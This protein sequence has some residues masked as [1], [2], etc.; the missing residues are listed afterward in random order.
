M[1]KRILDR[2]TQWSAAQ[3]PVLHCAHSFAARFRSVAGT[4]LAQS[5]QQALGTFKQ[6]SGGGRRSDLPYLR[7]VCSFIANQY[8]RTNMK[9]FDRSSGTVYSRLK[10][11]CRMT[12]ITR[13]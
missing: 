12:K 4:I 3:D 1:W 11:I 9:R 5:F 10:T 13:F 6:G 2:S 8:E 7:I